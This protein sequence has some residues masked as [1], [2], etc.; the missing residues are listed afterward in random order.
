VVFGPPNQPYGEVERLRA[1]LQ[2]QGLM[3][4]EGLEDREIVLRPPQ[5]ADIGE[6]GA[7]CARA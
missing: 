5:G 2:I 6:A 1:E 7:Q 4:F 3:D